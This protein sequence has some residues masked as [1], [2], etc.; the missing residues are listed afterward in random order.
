MA[1]SMAF[2]SGALGLGLVLDGGF[3]IDG[4]V[5]ILQMTKW[6]SSKGE[7]GGREKGEL[8]MTV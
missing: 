5:F 4:L 8:G 6:Q 3:S 1:L 7:R 2:Y